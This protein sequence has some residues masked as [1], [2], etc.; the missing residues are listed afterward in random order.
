MLKISFVHQMRVKKYTCKWIQV[1]FQCKHKRF[2]KMI[3]FIK[4][5]FHWI[6]ADYRQPIFLLNYLG[7]GWGSSSCGFHRWCVIIVRGTCITLWIQNTTW[8]VSPNLKMSC[9]DLFYTQHVDLE[10]WQ[11]DVLLVCILTLFSDVNLVNPLR[12]SD[13]MVL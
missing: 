8:T 1:K 11:P 13:V 5:R 2:Q 4:I 3:S 12:P 9:A 7:L 6:I 10:S